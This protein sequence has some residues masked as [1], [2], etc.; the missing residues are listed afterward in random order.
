[1]GNFR[2]DQSYRLAFQNAAS[3]AGL[4]FTTDCVVVTSSF[5]ERAH[6]AVPQGM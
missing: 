3:I 5:A 2:S 4:V 1:M 6:A